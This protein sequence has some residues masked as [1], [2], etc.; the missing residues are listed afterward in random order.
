MGRALTIIGAIAVFLAWVAPPLAL[1]GAPGEWQPRAEARRPDE[2]ELAAL[3]SRI[4]ALKREVAA[5]RST[6]AE[7]EPL[8]ARAQELAALLE[9]RER[10]GGGAPGRRA[11]RP[12][13]QDLREHAD[14]LRD[15]ADRLSSATR[16]VL[17]RT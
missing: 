2:A 9:Q 16:A 17:P 3:A 4:E 7:L 13:P 5:G 15:R 10:A 11:L 14:A 12:D 6:G 8:L 1:G